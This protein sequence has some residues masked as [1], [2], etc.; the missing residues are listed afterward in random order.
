MSLFYRLN[1]YINE[2]NHNNS[3][4]KRTYVWSAAEVHRHSSEVPLLA[5][6]GL[7]VRPP[8][9][10]GIV[11]GSWLRAAS[12]PPP[13]AVSFSVSP[14]SLTHTQTYGLH[15]LTNRLWWEQSPTPTHSYEHI[16]SR[17]HK[18]QFCATSSPLWFLHRAPFLCI[19]WLCK[20]QL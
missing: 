14:P 1:A 13:L 10:V 12:H 2:K 9:H 6:S 11:N 3:H 5:G 16:G 4:M 8:Q 15:I 18:V 17:T 19:H 7:C 20:Q